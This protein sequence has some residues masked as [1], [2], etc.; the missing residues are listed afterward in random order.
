MLG[1]LDLVMYPTIGFFVSYLALETAW[2]FTA[3]R[4]GDKAMQPCIFKQVK[5][6]VISTRHRQKMTK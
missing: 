4:I 2:H 3:C 6:I 1:N 5:T